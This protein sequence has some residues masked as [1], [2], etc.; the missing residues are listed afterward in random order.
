M[1]ESDKET[2]DA[3]SEAEE[4]P[5]YST[6]RLIEEGVDFLGHP[7][8]VVA[9]AFEAKGGSKKNYTV[10]EAKKIVKDWLKS[11]VEVDEIEEGE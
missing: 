2:K 6:E 4:V 10:D 9:G 3:A 5:T 8:H 11:P 7:P 1:A